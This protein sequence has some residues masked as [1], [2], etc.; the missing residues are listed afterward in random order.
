MPPGYEK[1]PDYGG[2]EPSWR[3]IVVAAIAII[4]V[5][6]AVVLGLYIP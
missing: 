2:P 6:A 4:L 3:G 1:S 5:V